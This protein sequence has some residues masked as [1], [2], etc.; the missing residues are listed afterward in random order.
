MRLADLRARHINAWVHAQL[1]AHRGP[2]I[3]YRVAATLRTALN[4]AVHTHQLAYNPALHAVIPRPPSPER[5]C[6]NP[7]QAAAFLRHNTAAYADQLTD[8]FDVMI[9]T[10]LRRGEILALH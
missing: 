10:G 1:E 6:W 3:V 8:L 2:M 7:E 4:A 5:P 9:S